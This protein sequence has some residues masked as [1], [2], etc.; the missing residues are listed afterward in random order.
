MYRGT[1]CVWIARRALQSLSSH[2][3]VPASRFRTVAEDD[4]N[5]L[6]HPKHIVVFSSGDIDTYYIQ[7]MLGIT[8]LALECYQSRHYE[9][10]D[11]EYNFKCP[12]CETPFSAM[13]SLLQH[14]ES[15]TCD[16]SLI[17]AS[18]LS[19]FLRFLQSQVI[20]LLLSE[21]YSTVA[22][23]GSLKDLRRIDLAYVL[24]NV[25]FYPRSK[26]DVGSLTVYK[27]DLKIVPT[28]E[29]ED[30]TRE[31]TV[32]F[33]IAFLSG[34]LFPFFQARRTDQQYLRVPRN[35]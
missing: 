28:S 12:T 32:M 35:T 14:A 3:Q 25:Q 11:G 30:T 13:S 33:T 7:V 6:G 29:G 16:K 22:V 20:Q 24:S 9:C 2:E 26:M 21:L 17:G 15:D 10:D 4:E 27:T 5:F 18:P 19:K 23:F 1:A 34:S 8:N 31:C